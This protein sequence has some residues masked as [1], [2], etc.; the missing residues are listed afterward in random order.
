MTVLTAERLR[1]LLHYDPETGVFTWL[2]SGHGVRIGD[3]AGFKDWEGYR[4]IKIAGHRYRAH[5]LAWLYVHGQWPKADLDHINCDKA[6]NRFCNL[7][8][9]SCAQ[10]QANSY[11][12]L[13]LRKGAHSARGKWQSA[14]KVNGKNHWLGYFDTREDAA[15]AYATVAYGLWGEFSRPH[16]REVLRDIRG[17]AP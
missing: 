8:D 4:V 13:A 2:R 6:D 17:V 11:R 14:I 12:K 7:R 9:C 1:E 5:R 15:L 10:N 3:V 16:W